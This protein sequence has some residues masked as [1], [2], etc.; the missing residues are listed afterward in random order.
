MR[1]LE[2]LVVGKTII[3]VWSSYKSPHYIGKNQ[4]KDPKYFN[5]F[6]K[7]VIGQK[8]VGTS[9]KGKNVLVHLKNKTILVHMKMTGHLLYGKYEQTGGPTSPWIPKSK[10]KNNPLNDRFN[11]W[12]R[13]VF[14]LSNK[15]HLVLSDLRK[16]AK[17][18]LEDD[19]EKLGPDPF[20]IKVSEFIK[21]IQKH[22]KKPIKQVLLDQSVIAGVGN[23]YSDESLFLAKIHPSTLVDRLSEKKLK[24]LFLDLKKVLKKGITL[25]G[26][27]MSDYRTPY[28]TKGEFQ[29]KHN[30]YQRK[31]SP[32]TIKNCTGII[33]RI[34]VATRG[35][36][37]CPKCQKQISS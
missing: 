36:H 13:L 22:S 18:T 9:R 21:K 11:G 25:R 16:F 19:T 20:N 5:K 15:H 33:K 37:F 17:I 3:D 26:D 27:S 24:T 1:D 32:C 30:V 34:V 29:N 4:I 28:G 14:S 2:K 12:I 23:I 31:G 10:N 6:K 8:I 35:T 7:E